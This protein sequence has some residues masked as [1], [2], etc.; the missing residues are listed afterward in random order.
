M[1]QP[2]RESLLKEEIR[3][4]ATET[5]NNLKERIANLLPVW[6]ERAVQAE[7]KKQSATIRLD[8]VLEKMDEDTRKKAMLFYFFVANGATP[9]TA[10]SLVMG[11]EDE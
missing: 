8:P 2:D 4:V 10:M 9:D 6:A 3:L 7:V 5:A 1:N 11:G